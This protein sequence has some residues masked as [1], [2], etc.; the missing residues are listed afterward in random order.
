MGSICV[1]DSRYGIFRIYLN[2][3]DNE[4]ALWSWTWPERMSVYISV[5]YT[6]KIPV[7]VGT[8]SVGYGSGSA[9]ASVN[10]VAIL[11]S[12]ACSVIC[13]N[14]IVLQAQTKICSKS[15]SWIHGHAWIDGLNGVFSVKDLYRRKN[16]ID[17]PTRHDRYQCIR[18]HRSDNYCRAL[19]WLQTQ[20][21]VAYF[22]SK[23][24]F[25]H[26]ASQNCKTDTL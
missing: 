1:R 13:I 20:I 12:Y 26:R 11:T 4:T 21:L 6:D 7:P 19:S 17:Y 14:H 15:N 18:S 3:W 25:Q 8:V 16:Y 23:C 2:C 10:H 22:S 24:K 5:W 9:V